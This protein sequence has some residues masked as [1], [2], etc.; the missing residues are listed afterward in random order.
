VKLDGKVAIVTAAGRGIG[1]GIAICL[2]EAGANVVV[3]SFSEETTAATAKAVED[4]G[5]EALAVVGDITAPAMML[6]VVERAIARFGHIDILVNNVGAGPKSATEPEPGPLGPVAALWDA[7]YQQNLKATVLMTEAV[8]PHLVE[9]KSGKIINISSIAGRTSLSDKML[10]SFV[11]PS[12]GAMKAGLIN[13]TQTLAELLGPHNINVN[14]VCPGIV[15]TDS[16]RGNAERAV[17]NIPEFKGQDPREWFDGIARGDYPEIF[18]RTP[19]RR[20]QSVED[21]G[22][23]VVFLACDE[24]MNMTGQSLMVDGGMVKI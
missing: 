1:R 14:A 5:R 7:L 11:H 20:D 8:T 19:L 17:A 23:A 16:W 15:Y 2:A 21:I 13:Y 12:Y 4:C 24:S 10:S 18:D 9:Q 3:N 22:N 6:E